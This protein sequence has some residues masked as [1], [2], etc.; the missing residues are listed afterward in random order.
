MSSWVKVNVYATVMNGKCIYIFKSTG[1]RVTT[2]IKLH[3]FIF[4]F[5]HTQ[6]F[7]LCSNCCECVSVVSFSSPHLPISHGTSVIKL[8]GRKRVAEFSGSYKLT[9]CS[10]QWQ[11]PGA[12]CRSD[13]WVESSKVLPVVCSSWET[14][15]ASAAASPLQSNLRNSNSPCALQCG[16]SHGRNGCLLVGLPKNTLLKLKQES[17][18]SPGCALVSSEDWTPQFAG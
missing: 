18:L 11:L 17:E 12:P 16:G 1:W 2:N 7:I 4:M 3:H 6:D 13:A 15:S 9:K 10:E 14:A 5:L 8:F